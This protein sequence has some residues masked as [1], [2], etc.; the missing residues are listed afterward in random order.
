M[1][2]GCRDPD[3]EIEIRQVVSVLPNDFEQLENIPKINGVRLS[4]DM[5]AEALNLLSSRGEDYQPLV[6]GEV[7]EETF[8]IALDKGKAKKMSVAKMLEESKNV[9]V[10]DALDTDCAVG[11]IQFVKQK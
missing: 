3:N 1:R 2:R 5:S 8:F 7:T 11:T 4:G 10:T 9:R 6:V